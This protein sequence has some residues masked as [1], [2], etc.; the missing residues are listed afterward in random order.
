MQGRETAVDSTGTNG[1]L[2]RHEKFCSCLLA[3]EV[4][5]RKH[6]V[7][8]ISIEILNRGSA[9]VEPGGTTGGV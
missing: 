5:I 2:L 4:S 3:F 6:V 1:V 9:L 8:T 7:H